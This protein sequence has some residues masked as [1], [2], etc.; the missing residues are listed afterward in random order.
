M[1]HAPNFTSSPARCNSR[2]LRAE[3]CFLRLKMLWLLVQFSSSSGYLLQPLVTQLSRRCAATSSAT[4]AR[5]SPST[6]TLTPSIAQGQVKLPQTTN[7]PNNKLQLPHALFLRPLFCALPLAWLRIRCRWACIYHRSWPRPCRCMDRCGS[8]LRHG[9]QGKGQQSP[10][11]RLAC[12]P[13]A[14]CRIWRVQLGR[15]SFKLPW[16]S[17]AAP[18]L[19]KHTSHACDCLCPVSYDFLRPG[20]IILC[21]VPVDTFQNEIALLVRLGVMEKETMVPQMGQVLPLPV[22]TGPGTHGSRME[23]QETSGLRP[24]HP[25]A[26]CRQGTPLGELLYPPRERFHVQLRFLELEHKGTG[27]FA[28]D[29]CLRLRFSKGCTLDASLQACISPRVDQ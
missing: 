27:A 23:L 11:V 12:P 9:G 4:L 8:W 16:G 26:W 3:T 20:T 7:G 10:K 6:Q 15:C 28:P 21:P 17:R 24:A 19:R 29:R 1:S 5:S 18:L 25:P 2:S 13:P 22:D 14:S